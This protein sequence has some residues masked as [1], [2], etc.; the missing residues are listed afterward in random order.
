MSHTPQ[1]IL[2]VTNDGTV[3]NNGYSTK[4]TKGVLGLVDMGGEPTEKGLPVVSTISNEANRKFQMRLGIADTPISRNRSDKSWDSR[5]FTLKDVVNVKV[6][7][8]SLKQTVDE[9]WVGYDGINADTAI[10]LKQGETAIVDVTIEG[11]GLGVLG[12]PESKT[13]LKFYISAPLEGDFTMQQII[14]EAI[15]KFK[16][17]KLFGDV[18]VTNFLDITPVNSEQPATLT[19]TDF[20]LYDLTVPFEGI[21]NNIALVKVQYPELDVKFVSEIGGQSKF[22]VAVEGDTA[23]A[24]FVITDTT[25]LYDCG[26]YDGVTNTTRTFAWTEGETCTAVQRNISIQLADN[27][28]G[29]NRLSELQEFYPDLTIVAGTSTN[30]QT[31]YTSSVMTDFVCEECSPILRDIFSV[32]LPQPF[33]FT[34]WELTAEQYSATA[35]MGIR[36][37]GKQFIVAGDERYRDSLP[38][39]HSFVKITA[40]GGYPF[41]QYKNFG[42][43]EGEKNYFNV[44]RISWGTRPS[45]LGM[46]YYNEEEKT[47]VYYTRTQRF[48]DND[49]G[50][51]ML[52]NESLL[53]PLSQYIMYT[54]QVKRTYFAQSFSQTNTEHFFYNILA[55]VGKHAQVEAF[56]NRIATASGLPTVQAYA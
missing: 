20:T 15:E 29:E 43:F 12:Y 6:S 25:I 47:R 40:S 3:M 14:E 13:S 24:N 54:V 4:L 26:E 21:S 55:E 27:D 35:L 41:A 31:V 36:L 11:D 45:A 16:K 52:G 50:N 32:E 30:C 10:I 44:K 53:K 51:A 7:A 28:C 19:G 48:C 37:K 5:S 17:T 18:P 22:T 38:M 56:V 39:F 49:F 42:E 23:P 34:P 9:V 33:E 46:D 1:S 2:F 8:P